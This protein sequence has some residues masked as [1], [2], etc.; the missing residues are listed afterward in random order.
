MKYL[1]AA[2]IAGLIGL[3]WT[4]SSAITNYRMDKLVLAGKIPYGPIPDVSPDYY[5]FNGLHAAFDSKLNIKRSEEFSKK[6]FEDLILNSLDSNVRDNFRL[7]LKP[8]LSLSEEYQTDPFWI[9]AV[10]MVESG[11]NTKALSPK[12]AKGLMQIRP[13]TAEHLYALMGKKVKEEELHEILHSPSENIEIGIF[14]LKKLLHNFRLD[15]SLATIAYNVGPNKL[16]GL[17]VLEDIDTVNFSYLVKVQDRYRNLT[18][19]YYAELRKRPRPYEN[20]FVIRDQGRKLEEN[21][22]KLYTSAPKSLQ[23]DYFLTSE[24]LDK[25]PRKSLAF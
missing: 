5:S 24:N 21:L 20:T 7:Y 22:L 10:M 15:Y 18:R 8:T 12:N 11:F 6:E 1:K 25:N 14:Y 23:A 13:D 4:A 3:F 19:N 17:L 16:K 9:I 2:L